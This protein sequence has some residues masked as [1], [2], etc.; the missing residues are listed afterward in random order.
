M[1]STC[2]RSRRRRGQGNLSLSSP[3]NVAPKAKETKGLLLNPPV[4]CN[5]ELKT[6]GNRTMYRSDLICGCFGL[7]FRSMSAAERSATLV[8]RTVPGW[9]FKLLR[10]F[11]RVGF[12]APVEIFCGDVRVQGK[13]RNLSRGGML[14]DADCHIPPQTQV[15]VSFHLPTGRAIKS[16]A[17]VVHCRAGKRLGIEFTHMGNSDWNAVAK[18]TE[19]KESYPRR[20]IRIPERLF[21]DLHWNQSAPVHYLAQTILLSR[22]GCLL[23]SQAAPPPG[24]SLV[25]WCPDRRIGAAARVVSCEQDYGGLFMLALEFARDANFWGID[26]EPQDWQRCRSTSRPVSLSHGAQ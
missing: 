6:Y 14:L 7:Y 25:I 2:R 13:S 10:R 12:I 24:T 16:V 23:L 5:P 17:R 8:A 15:Y 21:V 1:R 20:S 4:F 22:H 9:Q 26:F 18:S 11:P 3:R 19:I